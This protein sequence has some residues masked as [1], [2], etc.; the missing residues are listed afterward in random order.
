MS[1]LNPEGEPHARLRRLVSQ[2][3]RPWS[4]DAPAVAARAVEEVMRLW[5]AVTAIRW[6]ATEDFE[7]HG[8]RSPA[9]TF[10]SLFVAAANT[11]PRM[12]GT[13]GFDIGRERSAQLTFGGK[14]SS[15]HQSSS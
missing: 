8:L 9:G 4:A 6:V 1:L 2:A 7:C 10:L 3:F 11:N 5:P 12:F 13:E 14:D 15:L